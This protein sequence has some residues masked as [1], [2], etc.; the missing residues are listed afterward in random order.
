[1]RYVM[2]F[3][4]LYGEDGREMLAKIKNSVVGPV[5]KVYSGEEVLRLQTDIHYLNMQKEYCED[6]RNKKYIMTNSAGKVIGMGRPGYAKDDN[7]DKT[8]WPAF[9]VPKVDH[10]ELMLEEQKYLL[11]M[12]N[13]QNYILRNT[14]GDEVLSIMHKGIS[15]GWIFDDRQG[16]PPEILCGVFIFC[17]YIEQENELLI[18]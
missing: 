16:F 14:K 3:S 2:K 6:V 13:G 15:G 12:H 5:R 8:G 7:P 17:R 4:V 9:R 11:N 1:M 10:A 18:V